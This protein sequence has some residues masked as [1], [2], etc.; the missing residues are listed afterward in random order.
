MTEQQATPADGT[1]PEQNVEVSDHPEAERYEIRVD[2]RLAGFADY[3]RG[4]GQIAFTHT[5]IDDA[6]GGRGL[7]GRLARKSLDDALASGQ[8]VLPFCPFY[9]GWIQKHPD[10]LE[11]VPADRRAEFDL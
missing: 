8:S 2:G 11:L 3:Q 9:R 1:P 5:E 10:Y 6:Y 4:P 7:A